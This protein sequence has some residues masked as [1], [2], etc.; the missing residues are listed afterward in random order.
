MRR[1]FGTLGIA[2]ELPAL[3]RYARVLTRDEPA[4]EDLVHDALL[5]AY[6]KRHSFRFGSN[7]RPWLFAIMH[8]LFISGWRKSTAERKRNEQASDRQIEA[9]PPNQEHA[10]RLRAISEA[11]EELSDDHRAALH[12]VVVE[13]QSYQD[14]A[15]ALGIPIGTLI[16]RL[17]RARAALR[18]RESIPRRREEPKLRLVGRGSHD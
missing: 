9:A 15:D 7:P 12:L 3:H 6:E 14:A 8:N 18:E 13:G 10:L 5:R 4:A 2:D 1:F 17:G 16:S 11:F